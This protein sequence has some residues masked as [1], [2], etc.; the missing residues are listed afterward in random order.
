MKQVEIPEF[1]SIKIEV[2]DTIGH[3]ILNRPKR[4]NALG[5]TILRE[6]VL[7]AQWL[8]SKRDI[9][10]V[11]VKGEG[12]VFSAGADLKILYMQMWIK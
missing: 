8:D 6:L 10:V 1:E 11:I 3:L 7:A 4:Y 12:G 2:Q 5:A 9:R